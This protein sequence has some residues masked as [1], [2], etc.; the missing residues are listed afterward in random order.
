MMVSA[1]DAMN[2]IRD[3]DLFQEL[4]VLLRRYRKQKIFYIK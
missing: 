3:W 2:S 4:M 1:K